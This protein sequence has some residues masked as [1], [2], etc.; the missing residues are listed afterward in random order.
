MHTV[1]QKYDVSL[2]KK[3]NHFLT[4]NHRKDGVIDQIEH[5]KG[6]IERK[7]KD[8]Q[9]HV[10]NNADVS[11]QDVRIYCNIN[12]FPELSF[13]GPYSKPHGSRGL[14]KHY[15]LHF[16]PKLGLGICT[17]P[18]ACVACTSILDKT[19]IYGIS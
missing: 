11:R 9:Y 17:I 6:F 2:A 10:Q 12:Q 15:H 13:C 1:T 3:F 14:S 8:I 18:C 19:W 4:K 5:K 7:W 16:D